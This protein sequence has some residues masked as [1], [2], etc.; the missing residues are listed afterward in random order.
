MT[1]G[2][3][4][5][6]E[7]QFNS[8][9]NLI[10]ENQRFM[11]G[12][13]EHWTCYKVIGTGINDFRNTLTLNNDSAKILTLDLTA[14]FVNEE[15]DDIINGIADV[16]TNL[17]TLSINQTN[18]EGAPLQTYQLLTHI[19]YNGRT[20][21]RDVVWESSNEKIATVNSSGLVTFK[22]AGTCQIKAKIKDNPVF[23]SSL[24]TVTNTPNINTAIMISPNVNYILEGVQKDFSV[25]LYEN[26]VEQA[27][28]F[29][30]SCNPNLVPT[31]S[32]TFEQLDGNHFRIKNIRRNDVSFLTIQC[33]SGANIKTFDI[34]LRGGW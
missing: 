6:I 16:N 29:T 31:S 18:V 23:S 34:F 1:P 22:T 2:G 12:N 33:S 10:K 28:V 7:M 19:T 25:F 30:I 24:I 27:D 3:F 17:Y 32:Y 11:F 9:S 26:D 13:P 21:E 8:R 5:H 15:L 14:D 4:L 20:V